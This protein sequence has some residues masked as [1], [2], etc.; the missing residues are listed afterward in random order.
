MSISRSLRLGPLGLTLVLAG[1][2]AGAV[3]SLL[4]ARQRY[5]DRLI[6]ASDLASASADLLAAGVVEE[7]V[8]RQ[9]RGPGASAA[10]RSAAAA[11]DSAAARARALAR[12]DPVSARLLARQV[13]AERRARR[14]G[15]PPA[16]GPPRPPGGPPAAAPGAPA[17]PLAGPL[18]AAR[19]AGAALRER[20]RV[21][22]AAAR[23]TSEKDTRHALVLLAIAGVLTLLGAIA[24]VASLIAGL[25]RP[26]DALV[27]ATGRLAAGDLGQR[28]E[29]Q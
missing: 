24:I 18:G 15:P 6:S 4:N 17:A 7:A 5:E 22:Q 23:A 19:R 12:A 13:R 1:L 14:R 29:P 21:R 26:L 16:P 9:D 3:A 8:L 27:K 28:V 2:S 25:R 11:F 10:R 20:Q